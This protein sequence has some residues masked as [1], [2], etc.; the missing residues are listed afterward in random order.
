DFWTILPKMLSI[1]SK[2]SLLEEFINLDIEEFCVGKELINMIESDYHTYYKES[3]GY[4]VD[5]QCPQ[6]I[7][8]YV[9]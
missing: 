5:E 9:E 1:D 6:S 7:I 8:F 3:C 2:L 4:K